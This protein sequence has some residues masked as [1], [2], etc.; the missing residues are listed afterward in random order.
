M[1]YNRVQQRMVPVTQDWVDRV[2]GILKTF[3]DLERRVKDLLEQDR[4]PS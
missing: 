1:R 3:S 2:Q 4:R